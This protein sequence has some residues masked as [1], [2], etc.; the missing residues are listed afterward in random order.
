MRSSC[1]NLQPRMSMTLRR[2]A[3]TQLYLASGNVLIPESLLK[4]SLVCSSFVSITIRMASVLH[5]F[6][7]LG[8]SVRCVCQA[9]HGWDGSGPPIW[10]AWSMYASAPNSWTMVAEHW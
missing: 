7:F 9:T 5:S 3:R 2:V 10:I 8:F 4:G 1:V 6:F